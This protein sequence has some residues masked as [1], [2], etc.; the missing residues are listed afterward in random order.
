M[1]WFS[2]K[3]KPETPKQ[4]KVRPPVPAGPEE[5]II[6][7]LKCMKCKDRFEVKFSRNVVRTAPG[8]CPCCEQVVE[9]MIEPQQVDYLEFLR[10]ET[11]ATRRLCI[12]RP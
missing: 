10:I 9:W 4:A 7:A 3:S 11:E 6:V 2:H 12:L 5:E 1:S 8:L